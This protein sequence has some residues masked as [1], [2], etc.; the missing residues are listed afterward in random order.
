[1]SLKRA[2]RLLSVIILTCILFCFSA[3]MSACGNGG[4]EPPP[5]S[6]VTEPGDDDKN[7]DK[8][9]PEPSG[10]AAIPMILSR[11]LLSLIIRKNP[12]RPIRGRKNLTR[13]SLKNRILQI[14]TLK[15]LQSRTSRPI[16]M[17]RSTRILK[18]RILPTRTRMTPTS[19]TSPILRSRSS[20]KDSR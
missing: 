20:P 16:P 4:D 11:N 12:N 19:L 18:N 1:M 9:D 3:A 15:T 8:K 2:L 7:G 5:A 13:L 17:S 6:V 10:P 14:P